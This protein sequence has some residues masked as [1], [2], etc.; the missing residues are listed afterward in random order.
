MRLLL[1][2]LLALIGAQDP[3]PG[4]TASIEGRVTR[5]GT[6]QPIVNARVAVWGD[7]GPDF[8]TTTDGNGHF[9]V[10]NMPAGIFNIEVRAEG[11]LP[12]PLPNM[13]VRIS[14]SD[15]QRLRRDV[16]LSVVS[17]VSGRIVDD[18]REPL[19]GVRVEILQQSRD[20]TGRVAWQGV[21]SAVTD[22]KG[23]Y[24][25]EELRSGD[26]YVRASRNPE[27]TVT[28]F[29]GTLDPRTAAPISLRDGDDKTADFH[30][31]KG[32]TFSIAGTIRNAD[33]SPLRPVTL[34]VL[35]QDPGIP[36]D[37]F[38]A[39]GVSVNE[40]F[41]LKGLL[42]GAYDLFAVSSPVRQS[43]PT[44]R[45]DANGGELTILSTEKID[46]PMRGAKGFVQIRDENV[47][48]LAFVLETGGD[49]S[50]HLKIVGKDRPLPPIRL[51]LKRRDDFLS[52]MA[53]AGVLE[54]PNSFRF[55]DTIPGI[56]DIS[57][58]I[59]EGNAYVADVRAFGRSIV[60]D[61]LTVG[62]DAVDSIEI[63]IDLEGSTVKGSL[64]TSTRKS[65][66]LVVLAPQASRRK[67][68][69]LFRA[70]GL[71]DPSQ[72]FTFSGV[73]PGLYSL[74]AFE[75]ASIDEV[76]P[77]L[78]P[79][80]LSLYQSQSTSISVEKGTTLTTAPLSLISR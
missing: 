53:R 15:R 65:P 64:A 48:D 60:D 67:G 10:S 69:A 51:V 31:A 56:Y 66:V 70:E 20:E 50:G 36:L 58:V 27:L 74:F 73:P 29:P 26:F 44:F 19:A 47:Q 76:V 33:D 80:F 28:Y 71:E 72:P 4:G 6:S 18:N 8:Q 25:F 77:F 57:A 79:D 7:R 78:S 32:R 22:G 3:A 34:F 37:E 5:A 68:N 52:G 40:K 59:R 14:L 41:E 46:I 45:I 24:R 17:S 54:P 2:A 9:V 38:L 43:I 1:A 12:N 35:P 55:S 21:A 42:P 11:Y 30:L 23:A 75:L 13:V 16:V 63:L 61:G 49:V 39:M 62:H